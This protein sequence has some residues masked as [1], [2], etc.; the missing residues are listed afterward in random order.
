M[1]D[2]AL[3][4]T[5]NDFAHIGFGV[6][7][8]SHIER[9]VLLLCIALTEYETDIP[10]ASNPS[11][12]RFQSLIKAGLTKRIEKLFQL[13]RRN[14]EDNSKIIALEADL[15][16]LTRVRDC[17]V[18]G[19]WERIDDKT[20]VVS[21]ASR[22]SIREGKNLDKLSFPNK[23]LET[24]LDLIPKTLIDLEELQKE[25]DKRSTRR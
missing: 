25:I 12:D 2:S 7:G 10:Y 9:S 22:A 6:V 15:T 23:R 17:Y 24:L 14:F 16:A 21:Y 3:R 18:H 1:N 20:L 8:F 19:L 13:Y 4:L 5:K 11:F